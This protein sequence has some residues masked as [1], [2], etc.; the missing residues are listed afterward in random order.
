MN[1]NQ[2]NLNKSIYCNANI[3]SIVS[4]VEKDFKRVHSKFN[5]ET[6]PKFVF[7]DTS[8]KTLAVGFLGGCF[9]TL[10]NII[11]INV[12]KDNLNEHNKDLT[13]VKHGYW[14]VVIRLYRGPLVIVTMVFLIGINIR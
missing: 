5:P 10:L 13:G 11:I 7:K 6:M 12:I 1:I 14:N 8:W 3:T 2:N 4:D 9:F